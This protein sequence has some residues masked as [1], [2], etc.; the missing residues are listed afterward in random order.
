MSTLNFTYTLTN[1]TT[2][3]ADQVQT[4]LN[5][6][7][8]MINGNLDGSN[9]TDGG[10][11]AADILDGTLTATEFSA[12]LAAQ[13]GVND[14]ANVRRGASIIATEEARTNAAYG[15]L[16]TPD[17]VANVAVPTGGLVLVDFSALWKESIAGA[18]RAAIFIG[19][20]QLKVRDTDQAAP[21]LQAAA[22]DGAGFA[23]GTNV[24]RAVRSFPGGLFASHNPSG[25]HTSDPTTG[26]A[27][28]VIGSTANAS[29]LSCEVGG[30][31]RRF[32]V[33]AGSGYGPSGGIGGLCLIEG[34]AAG[35]YTIKVQ[36]LA[37]GGG[38]VTVKERRLQ[39]WVVG[40]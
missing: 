4:S 28:A 5:E 7:R 27:S 36:Y 18:A 31:N 11:A 23:V 22:I 8:A 10:I 32:N 25:A 19:A 13:L 35:T 29:V 38:T 40:F 16:A 2:A 14:G 30:G 20:N 9:F 34:I 3:D 26:V 37:S 15:T 39:V 6:L 1:G 24:Y 21:Q 33:G 12:T 17:Q